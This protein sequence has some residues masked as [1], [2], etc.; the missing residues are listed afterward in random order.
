MAHP[1]SSVASRLMMLVTASGCIAAAVIALL[2]RKA[3]I[4][5]SKL[6]PSWFSTLAPI[7][8]AAAFFLCA[9]AARAERIVPS[10]QR[11]VETTQRYELPDAVSI[12]AP[13]VSPATIALARRI[14]RE[15]R[16]RGRNVR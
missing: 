9:G 16:R 4:S 5:R 12:S 8:A 2:A 1:P 14:L 11:I 7:A 6:R 3:K 10:P 15:H 13:G